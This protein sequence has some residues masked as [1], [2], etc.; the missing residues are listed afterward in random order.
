MAQKVVNENVVILPDL[1]AAAMEEGGDDIHR[2]FY[3]GVT[4]TMKNLY[5]LEPNDYTKAYNL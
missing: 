3:V 1:T 4:R 5:I 2:V